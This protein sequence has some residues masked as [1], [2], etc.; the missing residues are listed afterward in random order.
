[1]IVEVPGIARCG[2]CAAEVAVQQLYDECP[3]CGGYQLQIID[4][5]Q[6]RIK[7]LEVE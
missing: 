7:E 3:Q 4:G 5:D 1:V 6:M 2:S